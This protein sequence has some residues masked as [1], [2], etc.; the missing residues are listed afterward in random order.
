MSF[1]NPYLAEYYRLTRASTD[2]DAFHQYLKQIGFPAPPSFGM[3]RF[4]RRYRMDFLSLRMKLVARYSWAIPDS[5][6]LRTI[7]RYGPVVEIGAGTGYWAAL[8]RARGVDVAAYDSCPLP[9]PNPWHREGA[10]PWSLV[11]YGDASSAALHRDRTLFL[12]WPPY[13]DSMA[14]D[15]LRQHGGERVIY[16]GEFGGCTAT[17]EFH[18]T[19]EREF[20]VIE[21]VPIHQWPGI[22]DALFFFRRRDKNCG[23]VP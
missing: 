13:T 1:P 12:C 3:T 6:A 14:L 18:N 16:V 9:G 11:E 5:R 8:L 15:A 2:L 22:H 10:F 4:P 20:E 19:L 23:E 17:D 7:A 21:Q